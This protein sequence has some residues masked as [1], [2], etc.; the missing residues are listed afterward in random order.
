MKNNAVK[1]G[2]LYGLASMALS[3]ILYFIDRKLMFHMGIGLGVGM[4]LMPLAFM[5]KAALDERKANDGSL[6][7]G[8]GLK[9]TFL[10][11]AIGFLISSIY[12]YVMINFLDPSLKE[13]LYET[14]MEAAE[15]MIEFF[16]GDQEAI[17]QARDNA[18]PD[19]VVPTLSATFLNYLV[20]LIFPGFIY[21]LIVSAIFKREG[22]SSFA[23]LD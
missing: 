22:D 6:S 2:V 9:V 19:D 15:S 10:T 5:I 17:E 1:N 16:G 3:F 13:T 4:F 23:H 11:F 12:S 14:S 7:F 18:T 21:S 8:E 20:Y